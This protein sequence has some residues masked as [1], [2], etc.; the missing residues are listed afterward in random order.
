MSGPTTRSFWT[1]EETFTAN[2]L[3]SIRNSGEAGPLLLSL[4]CLSVPPGRCVTY[5]SFPS[6]GMNWV[7]T[8]RLLAF[9]KVP[10]PKIM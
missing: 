4:K 8:I 6:A 1:R 7:F 5:R 3:T 9:L 2:P 10:L